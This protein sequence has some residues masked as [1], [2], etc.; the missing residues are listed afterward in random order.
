M[1]LEGN[2]GVRYTSVDVS[3]LSGSNFI[4]VI[5]DRGPDGDDPVPSDF[6]PEAVAFFN[7]ADIAVQDADLSTDD[8]WLPSLNVKWNLNDLAEI[9]TLSLLNQLI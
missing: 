5:E 9:R 4:N 2:I 7:Q 6:S 3:G 1:S 8:A